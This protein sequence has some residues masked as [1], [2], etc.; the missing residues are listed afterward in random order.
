MIIS[1]TAVSAVNVPLASAAPAVAARPATAA[2]PAA[3][4]QPR[5]LLLADS[6]TVPGPAP[7][8][9]N[10][11]IEQYEAEQDGFAVT[12]VTGAQWDAMTAAQFAAYQVV[13]I[14]DPTCD[15]TGASFAKAVTDEA[16][17]EP[18][19]MRSGGNK[20]LI[21]TDPVY[22]FTNGSAPNADK[23]LA[24]GIAY[25]GAVA[26]ATGAYIDLSC[27]YQASPVNTP[28]PL[29]N[30]LS[31]HGAS[32]FAV[33]GE[34]TFN[35][36]ATG[37]NV[38]AQTG[39]T[40]GLADA[41]LSDWNC[42]VHEAFQKF[43]SDYT[44]LALAP[45]GSG[46]PDS[47]CAD[48]VSTGALAC[49]SPYIMISGAGVVVKS[50]I[51]LAPAAQTLAVGGKATLVATVLAG[52]RPVV[53]G[54]VTFSVDGGPN[55]GTTLSGKTNSAGKVSFAYTDKKGAGAD[56]VSATYINASKVSQKA[57]A[58]V[59]WGGPQPT[60]LATSLAGAGHSGAKLSV[61]SGQPAGDIG[62]L[63]GKNAAKAAGTMTFRVYSDAKCTGLLATLTSAVRAGKATSAPERLAPGTYYWTAS[64]GGDASNKPSASGCGTEI[65]R[66]V[67]PAGQPGTAPFIDTVTTS[68]GTSTATA[69]ASTNVAGDLVVAFIAGNGP[70]TQRQ[71]ATVSGGG[72]TWYLISRQNPA[73]SDTEVWAAI[74]AGQLSRAA[75]TVTGV[76]K[77]Y[78]ESI[79]LVAFKNAS[80]IGPESFASAASGAPHGSLKTATANTWVFAVGADWRAYAAR[81]AGAGQ[82]LI[83]QVNAPGRHT[84]WVQATS[85]PTPASGTTVAIND[86]RPTTDPYDLLL[87]G[88]Q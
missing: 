68:W 64:Y 77:G 5:A 86:T 56:R 61:P 19:V 87:V 17:W 59:T 44:P 29:L 16:T 50:Q 38:V 79:T 42:S 49:G 53:G 78:V 52:T 26:G 82:L 36:C 85:A 48:D 13:I 12:S 27:A 33:V 39:P 22:H 30:G 65:L 72:L 28:V 24:N 88:I 1:V 63:S 18:V 66:V 75:V 67:A 8:P 46:F 74:P 34:A 35:A 10:E 58:T 57:V 60:A 21:G 9:A 76:L 32:Q 51:T 40:K 62:T 80:G 71:A 6:V 43:P 23:L 69:Q 4:A 3:A 73:G 15:G 25:A 14:G 81:T 84:V 54:A 41:D 55:V 47:Y 20:V 70:G 45:A 2:A 31:T 37:V 83:S 11:S 7:A